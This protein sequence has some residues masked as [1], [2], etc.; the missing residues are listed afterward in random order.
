[1]INPKNFAL[2][3]EYLEYRVEWHLVLEET[4]RN[5]E[6]WLYH[7][8]HWADD[9]PFR[10]APKIQ[11]S[12]PKYMLVARRDGKEEQLSPAYIKKVIRSAKRFLKWLQ[13]HKKHRTLNE[14]YLDTLR[15]PRMTEVPKEPESYSLEEIRAIAKAPVETN[16]ERRTRAAIIFMW[17]SGIRVG[18][19]SSLPIGAVDIEEL[20]IKQWPELGVRTKNKKHGT[21]TFIPIQ[22]LLDVLKEWDSFVRNALPDDGLWFAPLLPSTGEIDINASVSKVGKNRSRIV[23]R[24]MREWLDKVGLPYRSPHKCRHGFLKFVKKNA[25]GEA[26]KEAAREALMQGE[27]MGDTYGR[28]DHNDQKQFL[29]EL[30]N[31]G[32]ELSIQDIP[33]EVLPKLLKIWELFNE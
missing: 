25:R 24:N 14:I 1:L 28:F 21:T 16:K 7:L 30:V 12:F 10:D 27:Y 3:K 22:D 18:A 4:A 2:L 29:N 26:H 33:P 17:L 13:T 20:E 32:K 9:K 5:E 31:S 8:L 6:T 11:P 23:S 15:A 19:F